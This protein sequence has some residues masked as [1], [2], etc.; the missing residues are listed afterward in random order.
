MLL[1]FLVD[2]CAREGRASRVR[3]DAAEWM[4]HERGFTFMP[5]LLYSL[6]NK[7]RARRVGA[8]F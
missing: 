3:A 5:P 6:S 1:F 7:C 8:E 2:V 4:H